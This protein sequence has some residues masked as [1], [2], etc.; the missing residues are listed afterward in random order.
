MSDLNHVTLIGAIV[1]D[2]TTRKSK[3][4]KNIVNFRVATGS[5]KKTEAGWEKQ[6]DYHEVTAFGYEADKVVD[7]LNSKG[8]PITVSGK[9]KT[10]SWDAQDGTKKYK[11][12]VLAD[13][14]MVGAARTKAKQPVA[15]QGNIVSV[16]EIPF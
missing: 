1:S 3:D 6:N 14:I 9:L 2:I 4:G 12:Y 16:E 10:D 11:T 13:S 7:E 5:S 8:L 15:G